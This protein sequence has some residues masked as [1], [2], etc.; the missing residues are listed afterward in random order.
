M[1]ERKTKVMPRWKKR[2][3]NEKEKKE[4]GLMNSESR[5]RT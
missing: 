4:R 2:K 3:E 5:N 1:Q